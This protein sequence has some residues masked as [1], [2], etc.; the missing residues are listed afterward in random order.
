MA[1]DAGLMKVNS[2]TSILEQLISPGPR[3][4]EE[5]IRVFSFFFLLFFPCLG[6]APR[7]KSAVFFSSSDARR[8][9]LWQERK[10]HAPNQAVQARTFW[11]DVCHFVHVLRQRIDTLFLQ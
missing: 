9:H 1:V 2:D 3:T 7:G 11:E 10:E 5:S 4:R 6:K 8:E